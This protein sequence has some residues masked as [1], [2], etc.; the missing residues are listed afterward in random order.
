MIITP[1]HANLLIVDVSHP[2]VARTYLLA[3]VSI[4]AFTISFIK[5]HFHA[6]VLIENMS[7]PTM[8]HISFLS[9]RC[10]NCRYVRPYCGSHVLP[11]SQVY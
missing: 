5:A 11:V 3:G 2:T 9:V 1:F 7:D 10:I 6:V 4:V 8:A